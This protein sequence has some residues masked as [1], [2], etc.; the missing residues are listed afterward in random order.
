[1]AAGQKHTDMLN[2]EVHYAK[3]KWH[4]PLEPNIEQDF[5]YNATTLQA[6]PDIQIKNC[7]KKSPWGYI[8]SFAKFHACKRRTNT[9]RKN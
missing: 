7:K 3:H 2:S 4:Q 8:V 5:P 6:I 1:M 9:T